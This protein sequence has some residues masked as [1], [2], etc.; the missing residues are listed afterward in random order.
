MHTP[1][2]ERMLQ[3]PLQ[4]VDLEDILQRDLVPQDLVHRVF[5]FLHPAEVEELLLV[6]LRAGV[7]HNIGEDESGEHDNHQEQ[8]QER[9]VERVMH[10]GGEVEIAGASVQAR[11][12]AAVCCGAVAEQPGIWERRGGIIVVGRLFH[13]G[14][15]TQD[16]RSKVQCHIGARGLYFD[17]TPCSWL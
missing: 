7:P 6:V 8:L 1:S 16:D 11:G 14:R 9:Q 13:R 5:R 10:D 15:P 4:E 17:G 3:A 2:L 12:N